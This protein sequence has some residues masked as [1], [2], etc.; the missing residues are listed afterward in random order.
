MK[1]TNLLIKELQ[2]GIPKISIIS[3]EKKRVLTT[4]CDELLDIPGIEIIVSKKGT[5]GSDTFIFLCPISYKSVR[6]FWR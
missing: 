5:D 1:V 6:H 4:G 3:R 2:S